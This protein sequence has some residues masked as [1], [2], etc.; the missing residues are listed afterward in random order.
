MRVRVKI[1]V[2]LVV[3][4]GILAALIT[5]DWREREEARVNISGRSSSAGIS[6]RSDAIEISVKDSRK[7]LL[8]LLGYVFALVAVLYFALMMLMSLPLD[9]ISLALA[10]KDAAHLKALIGKEDEFGR[11]AGQIDNFFRQKQDLL[12]EISNRKKSD[13]AL[14][15]KM[16]ELEE[17]YEQLKDMQAKLVQSEKLAAL[18]RFA[19]G[20]AHE[21]KNPLAVLL[22]GLEYINAKLP[23]AEP[24]VREALVKVKEAVLR[25]DMVMKDLLA[26][27]RPSKVVAEIV[28]PNELIRDAIIFIELFK[29]KSDTSGINIRQELTDKDILVEV[30]KNQMQ[31]ALFNVLMNAIEAM[32][33]TGDIFVRTYPHVAPL[34]PDQREKPA[35]VI[36]I[37]DTGSGI[38][39]EDMVKIFE[40]FF[41]T[42][43]DKKG[44]G[45]GLAIVKSIIDENRGSINMQSEI[46]KG[47]TVRI[48]LPEMRVSSKETRR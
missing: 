4:A 1:A 3:Y 41:T 33:M 22:G 21:V 20:V 6:G 9:S 44:T 29:Y 38:S 17:T 36:E 10:R 34:P 11:I 27:A 30:D 45:L 32:P 47:T 46:N 18:G 7:M 42:K 12:T 13:E 48:I 15:A 43:R 39:K 37:K 24:E 31:Q 8:V 2:L 23:E 25:A 35:C 40:P 26:F 16:K 19:S 5:E 28:H 14:V